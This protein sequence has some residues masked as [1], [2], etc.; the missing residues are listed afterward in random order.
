MRVLR[1]IGILLGG[2]VGLALVAIAAIYIISSSRINKT[3]TIASEPITISSDPARIERGKHLAVA[4]AKCVDCHGDNLAGNVV[5]DDPMIGVLA[6][7]NLTSGRGGLG[8]QL[9]DADWA[10]AIRHGVKP[11]GS[12]MLFMPI[13]DYYFLSDQDL[14]DIIAYAKSVPPVDQQMPA[15][16][17]RLLG[18]ALFVTGQ[19]PAISAETIDHDGPRPA[20]PPPGVTV[21]YGRYLAMTGGC[22]GCHGPGLS[23]GQVP[24]TPPELPPA[25]NLTPTGIGTWSDEDF[26]RALREGKRP[27][28]AEI[29]PFMPWRYTRL[30]TDDEIKALLSYLRTVPPKPFGNR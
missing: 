27:G 9:S 14:A 1:W 21:E 15:S 30:M 12:P 10:R 4:I 6:G 18:R 23:G 5:L 19:F 24:G 11:D 2:L 13:E 17:L 20:A 7:P 29:N 28:G 3:Y 25:A 26:F 8:G 22:T 16:E